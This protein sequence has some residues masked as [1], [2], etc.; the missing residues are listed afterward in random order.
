MESG[1][2]YVYIHE[3]LRAIVDP[4]V[5]RTGIEYRLK[6]FFYSLDVPITK[7][8]IFLFSLLHELGHLDT[9]EK[10][11]L[12][13]SPELYLEMSKH[14]FKNEIAD[15]WEQNNQ[16]QFEQYFNIIEAQADIFAMTN[17][18]EFWGLVEPI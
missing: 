13:G 14:R 15:I 5:F 4:N 16:I 11:H 17:F 18:P 9:F 6:T 1:N 3:D 2:F 10:L 8:S 12:A 7:E